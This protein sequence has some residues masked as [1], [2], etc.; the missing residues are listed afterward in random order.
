MGSL[1]TLEV[2]DRLYVYNF[3]NDHCVQLLPDWQLVC[4]QQVCDAE[5]ARMVRD[6]IFAR[7]KTRMTAQRYLREVLG[8]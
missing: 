5:Q 7:D 1:R 2:E 4:T 8:I 3:E 6:M